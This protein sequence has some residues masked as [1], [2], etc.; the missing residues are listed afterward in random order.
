[1]TDAAVLPGTPVTNDELRA[2]GFVPLHLEF[3]AAP[4]PLE[5]GTGCLW[6]TVGDVP[7]S[8]ELYAFTVAVGDRQHVTYVGRTGHLWMVTKGLLPR[9][10]GSRPGQRYG[11]PKYAGVTRQRMNILVSAERALGREVCHW[12]RPL[13]EELLRLEEETLIMRWR[14]RTTG[15]NRG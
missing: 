11:R 3:T 14:L 15:W 6:T 1:V 13:E 10:G 5:T 9:G 4:V 8:P 7:D 2:L 12:V